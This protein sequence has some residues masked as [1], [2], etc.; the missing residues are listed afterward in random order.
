MRRFV[1]VTRAAS[2]A[3]AAAVACAAAQA[4]TAQL[5]VPDFTVAVFGLDG[6][7][8]AASTV[9]FSGVDVA[10]A[11]ITSYPGPSPYPGPPGYTVIVD[12]AW[13][14]ASAFA[15]L[16]SLTDVEGT[17]TASSDASFF[18]PDPSTAPV[19]VVGAVGLGAQGEEHLLPW[20]AL[21]NTASLT[22]GGSSF[23]LAPRSELVVSGTFSSTVNGG[24]A[25]SA[26]QISG[27]GGGNAVSWGRSGPTGPQA[28]DLVFRNTSDVTVD[29]VFAARFFVSSVPEPSAALMLLCGIGALASA[30]RRRTPQR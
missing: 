6:T 8:N 23:L 29:G 25:S 16:T 5:Q 27:A 10:D 28:F 13:Y 1:R 3:A 7:A 30:R 2:L 15:S 18:A 17:V 9:S 21:E 4:G 19:V 12:G 14:G 22:L 20:G 11:E 26:I 24:S